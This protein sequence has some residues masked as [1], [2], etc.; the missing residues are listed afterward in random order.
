M[1]SILPENGNRTIDLESVKA[2]TS[3][4]NTRPFEEL[5]ERYRLFNTYKLVEK[6]TELGLVPTSAFYQK[7][8]RLNRGDESVRKHCVRMAHSDD[9]ATNDDCPEV[10]IVN[11][12]N[13]SSALEIHMGVFRLVCSNGLIVC[14]ENFGKTKFY[15]KGTSMDDILQSLSLLI[16]NFDRARESMREFSSVQV[17]P[18]NA[19]EFGRQA[20]I[21]YNSYLPTPR[22]IE[23]SRV[24]QPKRYE[25]KSNNLWG[26]YN[27]VQENVINGGIFLH[28]RDDTHKRS[29]KTRPIREITTSTR[30]NKDLWSLTQKWFD[31]SGNPP[32][33]IL[34]ENLTLS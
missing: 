18:D 29:A 13:G 5:S 16:G 20:L 21:H 1:L 22:A 17:S 33:D 15:H 25:D 28:G 7:A 2:I 11:S 32:V 4:P 12:H 19:I 26:L 30:L 34:S 6:A 24:I 8:R 14:N 27:I 10:V 23:P 31:N 3:I 9:L